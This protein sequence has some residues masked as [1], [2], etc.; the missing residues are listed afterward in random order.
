MNNKAVRE[1]YSEWISTEPFDVF[2]TVTSAKRTSPEAM[3]KRTR[4]IITRWA[5]ELYGPNA[6]R[7]GRTF[8][9]VIAIERHKSGNP[10]SHALFRAPVPG[11]S[12]PLGTFQDIATDTG[13]WCRVEA[14][15]SQAD[16]SAYCAKYLL[17]E[18]EFF[19]TPNWTPERTQPCLSLDPRM[20]NTSATR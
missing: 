17:K 8:E 18:G 19:F 16:V 12:L 9:G 20:S 2:L 1:A 10:H 15:R 11:D 5:C 7:S 3:L 4:Y 14:P 13:G 6:K